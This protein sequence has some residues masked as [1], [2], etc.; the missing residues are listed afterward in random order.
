[1]KQKI[2][3]TYHEESVVTCACGNSFT[4]G[5]TKKE[6]SV[7]V[8]SE[9]HPFFTGE[10]KF[11]DTMGRV[12]KFQKRK[13]HADKVKKD[14]TSKTIVKKKQIRPATLKEMM[15]RE[16]RKLKQKTPKM[17]SKSNHPSKTKQ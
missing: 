5:S 6:L 10:M 15:L 12:E 7:D 13:K 8:C 9:C 16:T 14:T 3:P 1:M 2:H 11:L 4:A 17:V